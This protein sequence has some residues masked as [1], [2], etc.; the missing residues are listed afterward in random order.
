MKTTSFLIEMPLAA[1]S[2]YVIGVTVYLLIVT[3]AAY[4]F[5][6]KVDYG[7]RPL[8]LAVV[9]PAHNE[10]AHI[11][12]TISCVQAS[13]Y[14]KGSYFVFVIADN[15]DDRT[16]EIALRAGA[17]VFR[18]TDP[19][20]R[21]KGQALDWFLRGHLSAYSA[22]DA[23]V[24]VDADTEVH[25]D[26]LKEIAASL[27]HPKVHAAQGYYGVSN[28]SAHWRSGLVS[29][30]FHVFNHLRPAGHNCLGGT[31]G[32][33]GNGMGFRKALLRHGWPAYSIVEDYEFSVRLLLDGIVVH[34]NPDAM[35]FSD[36][37][38]ERKVAETQRLRWEG[39]SRQMRG[40][41][42]RLILKRLMKEPAPRYVDALLNSFV[43]PLA[44]LVLGQSVCLGAA[45]ALQSRLAAPLACCLAVDIFYVLSG[46]VLRRARA[47]EWRSLLWA[48]F[49]V[50]WKIPLYIKMRKADP[51]VWKRT[52]RP[53]ELR[54]GQRS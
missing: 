24:M 16:E 30:A 39:A 10:E 50:L 17:R 46:L 51:T 45:L 5:R 53:S 27:K 35:V 22:A 7:G 42:I 3:L 41:F 33:R 6:K 48:P 23:V 2:L 19:A 21:G 44:L 29:A 25:P 9:I 20:R 43:P 26:F 28:A 40:T 12:Q 13:S 36:M 52:K 18:R 38:V 8:R 37:P 47:V 31:A 11:G 32:L 1:V 4:L 34:Y 14:P 49:Y 54:G 15:C